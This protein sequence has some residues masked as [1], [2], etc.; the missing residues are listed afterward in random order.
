VQS[1]RHERL[2]GESPVR[3]TTKEDVFTNPQNIVGH[4]NVSY[5]QGKESPNDKIPL[6]LEEEQRQLFPHP[7]FGVPYFYN[8]PKSALFV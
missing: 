5:I 4:G 8:I 6:G 7:K 2:Q 3:A 1:V